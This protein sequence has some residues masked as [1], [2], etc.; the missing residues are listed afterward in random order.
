MKTSGGNA[1]H[2]LRNSENAMNI[3]QLNVQHIFGNKQ[4]SMKSIAYPFTLMKRIHCTLFYNAHVYVY[5]NYF[6]NSC[7]HIF[8]SITLA[9]SVKRPLTS[10]LS[11]VSH[12][13]SLG[14]S[15]SCPTIWRLDQI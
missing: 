1:T 4:N 3:Q 7:F 2:I 10:L 6:K 12:R 13:S 5:K 15:S 8:L 11:I 14:Y 9:T